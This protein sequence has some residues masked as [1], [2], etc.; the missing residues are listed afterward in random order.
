MKMKRSAHSAPT[1]PDRQGS[2]ADGGLT[3]QLGDQFRKDA[4]HLFQDPIEHFFDGHRGGIHDHRILGGTQGC[5]AAAAITR[6]PRSDVLNQGERLASNP[7]PF[8]CLYR[9]SARTS[10]LASR[11]IF[12]GACGNTTVPMSRPSATR[13]GG[14]GHSAL[15]LQ[16]GR[17][18]RRMGGDARGRHARLL[19]ADRLA[20]VLL[21]QEHAARDEGDRQAGRNRCDRLCIIERNPA[22]FGRQTEDAIEGAAVQAM[23]AE[24]RRQEVGDRALARPG[25]AIDGNDGAGPA[26]RQPRGSVDFASL[27][28]PTGQAG[29]GCDAKQLDESGEGGL[30]VGTVVDR[31]SGRSRAR[32]PW[33]RTWRSDGRHA[34]RSRAHRS[35]PNPPRRPR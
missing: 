20:H 17:A 1:R 9:R 31:R 16:Q 18:H 25:R 11:K 8:N 15:A 27:V 23:P 35:R 5:G 32:P 6:I 4:P 14:H 21:V 12:N 34:H 13:P 22:A 33:R 19:G 7:F 3:R 26:W 29:A 10:A 24:P 28:H 30:D 2:A